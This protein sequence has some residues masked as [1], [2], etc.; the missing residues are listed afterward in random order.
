MNQSY[1]VYQDIGLSTEVMSASPHRLIQFLFEKGL[2]QIQ[3]A[4]KAILNKDAKKKQTAISGAM[5]VIVCLRECLNMQDQHVLEFSKQLDTTY[6]LIGKNLLFA[7]LYENA[8][9]LDLADT[10]LS[11]VKSGWDGIQQCET[12]P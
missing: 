4:K 12:T 9:Y 6:E 7:T 5:R 11:N 8:E 3:E 10:A 1:Q 2:S